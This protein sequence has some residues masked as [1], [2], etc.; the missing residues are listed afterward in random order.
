MRLLTIGLL[1]CAACFGQERQS[2]SFSSINAGVSSGGTATVIGWSSPKPIVKDATYLVEYTA[3]EK[4]YECPERFA[5]ACTDA[6]ECAP[7][8]EVQYFKPFV[9][10][11]SAIEFM[12]QFQ[13]WDDW[14]FVR[15][16]RI[17]DIPVKA[18][19]ETVEV[20]QPPKVLK[21]ITFKIVEDA[22]NGIKAPGAVNILIR[23]PPKTQQ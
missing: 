7:I 1:L 2:E 10:K 9:S 16:V 4:C 11:E 20:P 17:A 23:T 12:N 19:E 6:R 3:L 22:H 5:I 21:T 18:V 15:L 13:F 8:K 14:H